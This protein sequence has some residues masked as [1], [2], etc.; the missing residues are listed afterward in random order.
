VQFSELPAVLRY[1]VLAFVVFA[2]I[3]ANWRLVRKVI[4]ARQAV[5]GLRVRWRAR[6][7]GFKAQPHHWSLCAAAVFAVR[8]RQS[9]DGLRFDDER[10]DLAVG[11]AQAWGVT[12]RATLLET[13]RD[14]LLTGH[15]E[16]FQATVETIAGCSEVDYAEHLRKIET[17]LD[18]DDEERACLL[19][20]AK[21][22]RDNI[23]GAQSTDFVAWDMIRFVLLCQNGLTLDFLTDDEARD[24]LLL[25]ALRLQAAYAGWSDCVQNFVR[26]RAFW[27]AGRAT[28]QRTQDEIQAAAQLLHTDPVSPWKHV[29]WSMSLP[30]PHWLFVRALHDAELLKPLNEDERDSATGWT[31]ILDDALKQIQNDNIYLN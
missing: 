23:E 20:R 9:W 10:S 22:A 8:N 19:W 13:M 5:T 11:L 21:A 12:D 3:A 14:L 4:G 2:T 28:M 6:Q 26:G 30:T 15:R 25:P 24:F 17:D 7:A 29:T 16:A 1:L 18:V 31:R 27:V